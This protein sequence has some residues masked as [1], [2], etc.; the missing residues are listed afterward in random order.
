MLSRAKGINRPIT[1]H[2][3][4]TQIM[5]VVPMI[6]SSEQDLWPSAGDPIYLQLTTSAY[7]SGAP[8]GKIQQAS[9]SAVFAGVCANTSTQLE[10]TYDT[11]GVS[12]KAVTLIVCGAFTRDD[13]SCTVVIPTVGVNVVDS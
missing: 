7:V 13:G 5:A 10:E 9:G 4:V 8:V 6:R 1:D 2:C 11:M 3:G 12:V